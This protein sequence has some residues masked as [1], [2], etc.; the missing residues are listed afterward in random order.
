MNSVET[1]TL[2]GRGDV[3]LLPLNR[4]Q[5]ANPLSRQLM[6][7]LA[8]ATDELRSD[9]GVRAVVI[10]GAGERHFCGGADLRD[11]GDAVRGGKVSLPPRLAM[12]EIERLPQPVIAAINGAAMGGG[13][14]I[15]L[16]CDFRLMNDDAK[17]G[18]AEIS[19][20]ALRGGS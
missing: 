8:A 17:I 16:A 19:F 4:L 14:E 13:C 7:E 3:A 18:L 11:A 6:D 2:N 15:A 12:D 5:A 1:L 9:D 10:T 20:G